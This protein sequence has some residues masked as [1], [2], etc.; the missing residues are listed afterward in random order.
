MA[1]NRTSTFFISNMDC[2]EEE[3]LIRSGLADLEGVKDLSFDLSQ[4]RLQVTHT[5]DKDDTV[6]AKLKSI[7]MKAVRVA[8]PGS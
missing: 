6:L 5:L 7:G 2:S 8:A 4:R 1:A 3:R